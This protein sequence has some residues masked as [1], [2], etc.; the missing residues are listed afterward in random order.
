MFSGAGGVFAAEDSPYEV[1][2]TG[3]N[4]QPVSIGFDNKTDFEDY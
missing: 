4:G 2:T 3:F 1:K